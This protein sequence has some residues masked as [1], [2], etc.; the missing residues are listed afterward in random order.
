MV[1]RQIGR[2][3]GQPK[4]SV[5]PEVADKA[6]NKTAT[7]ARRK[8]HRVTLDLSEARYKRLKFAAIAGRARG[9]KDGTQTLDSMNVIIE[10]ALDD[11]LEKRPSLF[12]PL[13]PD[14]L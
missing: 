12:H 7:K 5:V 9:V 10:R 11:Y 13:G 6:D 1:D 2:K 4:L 3:T 14:D 8:P